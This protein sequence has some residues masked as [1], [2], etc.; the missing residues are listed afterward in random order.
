MEQ[1][2]GDGDTLGL[3]LAEPAASLSQFGVY[4]LGQIEDKIST[5]GMQYLP[6]ARYDTH[7]RI[8]ADAS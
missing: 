2:T 6:D 5:G 4:A 8:P 7:H 1:S 3:S